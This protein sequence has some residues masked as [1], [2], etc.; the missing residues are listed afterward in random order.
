M[1]N[2]S[3]SMGS[4]FGPLMGSQEPGGYSF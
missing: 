3:N 1:T 4:G 2:Q